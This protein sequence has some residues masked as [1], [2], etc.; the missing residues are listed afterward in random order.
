MNME[1]REEYIL[2]VLHKLE[3]SF[4]YYDVQSGEQLRSIK[5]RDYPHE[6]CL[7]PDRKKVYIAEMGVRGIESEGAGGHTIAVFDLKTRNR[8]APLIQ[9]SMTG[10]MGWP[11][12]AITSM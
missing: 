2:L 5:T 10:L 3:H 9:D 11:P 6:I 4:G 8:S 12:M 7:D 1:N